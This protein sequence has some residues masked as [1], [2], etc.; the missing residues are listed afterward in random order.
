MN[1]RSIN[2]SWVILVILILVATIVLFV[3]IYK[4]TGTQPNGTVYITN[5]SSCT[6]NINK[7]VV[8]ELFSSTYGLVTEANTYNRASTAPKYT[9]SIRS[10][11]C[12]QTSQNSSPGYDGNT[13][14]VKTSSITLDIPE[15]KQSW[16]LSFDWVIS[17]DINTDLGTIIPECL[18]PESLLYGDF[19]CYKILSLKEYGTDKY[20]PILQYMPYTGSGFDLSYAPEAK[21]VTAIIYIPTEEMNNQELIQ[22]SKDIV[23]YWF[24]HRGLNI[25]SYTVIYKIIYQ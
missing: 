7:A 17:E 15:A 6:P 14:L 24:E 18:P 16:K 19:N 21:T 3:V 22:N 25:G 2:K 8:D 1:N 23:P 12:K 4:K 11:S 10:G 5:L 13:Q 9:A 20:D